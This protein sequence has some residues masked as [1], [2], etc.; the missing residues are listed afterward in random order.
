MRIIQTEVYSIISGPYS[1]VESRMK[2]LK[3]T[4]LLLLALCLALHAADDKPNILII[5]A[6]DAGFS[7]LGCYGGEIAT[8]NLDKLAA[9]GLRFT[10]FY[11]TA[12]CW[13]TRTAL[14]TGCYA[15]QVAMDPPRGYF[16]PATRLLPQYL[17]P[18]GY[19]CYHSGKWHV[20]NGPRP[21]ADGG[22][23]HSYCL[24]DHDRHFAPRLH[25][26]DDQKL[27]QVAEGSGYYTTSAIA[28]YA[29][30]FLK[31]HAGQH[32][33]EPFFTYLAFTS[34]HFPIQ[35]PPEDIARYSDTYTQG[36]EKTR[37]ARYERLLK[38]GIVNCSL[39]MPEP[40]LKAPSGAP[41][42]LDQLG[43]N[44]TLYA[45][46]WISLTPGQQAF[47][48]K[49]ES[50][51]AAMIDRMD[52]EIGRVLDQIRTMGAWDNTVI[53][54]LS[55]NGAS[56]EILVRGDGNDPTAEPGSAHSFL[57]LGPGG[58]TVSNTPFRRH[59]IWTHEG[60]I[61]TPL[62]VHWPRG[63]AAKGELRGDV[64]HVIDFLPTLLELGGGKWAPDVIGVKA[65]PIHGR[66]LVPA[67][68]KDGGCGARESVWWNHEGNRALRMG[69][70]KLVS[71][72][73][74]ADEWEL[75]DLSKDR[76]EQHNLAVQETGRLQTMSARW[77]ELAAEFK[78]DA[79]PDDPTKKNRPKPTP[80]K[81]D[82]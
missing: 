46:P 52:R 17:T 67:F 37:A 26:L 34:P 2:F 62:I 28:D 29:V 81:A 78:H 70:W 82:D 14:L 20:S 5:V 30:R 40:Q 22:F 27:P 11:N 65:P 53:F 55:D 38:L 23:A 54:F 77:K 48:A 58:S 69:D 80:P 39:A 44:E 32:K 71:A 9:D 8:P 12:R 15:Q 57:C 50:I 63:I 49:K 64:G 66:S 3:A 4:L 74:D 16:P 7:D 21:C 42:I 68:A 31:E 75:Y 61:A 79:G 18:L 73:V 56:A 60:G 43:S 25:R 13:P 51:H 45:V 59:K 41:N 76:S 72:K 6:D 24:E 10:Q 33:N 47:Q 36:W 1:L 35:A 19:R